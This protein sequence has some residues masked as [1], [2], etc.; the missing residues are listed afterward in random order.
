MRAR[1]YA[2]TTLVFAVAVT[3][4]AA[5]AQQTCDAYFTK[6]QALEPLLNK[7]YAAMS[8][9][10]LETLKVLLPELESALNALPAQEVKSEVCG[11]N[12]I[13][14]YTAHQNAELNFQ[15]ARGVDIGFASNL[16]IV[17]QPE[18]N[19]AGTAYVTGWIKYELKDFTGALAAF[20]KGLAMFPHN[21]D[22]QTEKLATLLELKRYAD[23]VAYSDKVISESYILNDEQRAKIWQARAVGFVGTS[24]N[25]AADE[26]LTVSIRY[27]NIEA[28]RTLQSQVRAALG[29]P[30]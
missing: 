4:P 21:P 17:K 12:H 19:Q 1:H 5:F 16:P 13:N 8:P 3:A 2:F 28:T 22:L 11:G 29:T 26:A 15:R 14:A 25:K 6:S 7:A 18:L 10:N 23:V 20:E 24:D 27:S 9:K 30:N